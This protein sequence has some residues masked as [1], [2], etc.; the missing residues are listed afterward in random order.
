MFEGPVGGVLVGELATAAVVVAIAVLG[1]GCVTYGED[2]AIRSVLLVAAAVVLSTAV[3][4][5]AR[6][7]HARFRRTRASKSRGVD[8]GGIQPPEPP[9]PL[10]EGQV[11]L[12]ERI[13]QL[14]LSSIP[15]ELLVAAVRRGEWYETWEDV[16]AYFRTD[17]FD[18]IVEEVRELGLSVNQ[19]KSCVR[20]MQ[21]YIIGPEYDT[22]VRGF[23]VYGV[24]DAPAWA[25]LTVDIPD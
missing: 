15:T 10:S 22:S 18:T 25:G 9:P 14:R 21:S 20:R 1:T 2:D 12:I 13:R 5:G 3:S 7:G 19:A 23:G 17:S 6:F 4:L 8:G 11:Q 24:Y 16:E